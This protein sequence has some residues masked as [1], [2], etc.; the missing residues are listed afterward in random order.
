MSRIHRLLILLFGCAVAA[1]AQ[2][3][4]ATGTIQGTVL[5]A[6]GGAVAGARISA[7]HTG[8]GFTRATESNESGQFRLAA[9][10]AGDYDLRIEK[11]GFA[12]VLIPALPLAVGQSLIQRI[13]LKP[14]P[15]SE[16]LE[17]KERPEALETAATTAGVALGFERIE[18]APA[19]NRNYLN[20]VLVAPAVAPSSGSNAQRSFAGLRSAVSDSGFSFAGLRGRNNSLSIDG[21]DNRDETTGGNRVAI[22]LEMVREFRVSTA[23]VGA[24][25]GGAGGVLN[26]VTRSGTNIWHG[27]ATFF[28]QH[29]V[30]NARNPEAETSRRPRFRRRQ[31]GV[32]LM[33]PLRRDRTFFAWALE[34]EQESSEEWSS[35]PEELSAS[36]LAHGLYRGLFPAG[37][38]ETG[39]SFKADHQAGTQHSL[40][41]RY[42]FSRGRIRGDV[43]DTDNFA[44][45]SARGSSLTVDHSLVGGWIWVPTPHLVSDLRVQLARRSVEL[46]PNARGPLMEIPGLLSFG[47]SY[48]LD[49]DRAEDHFELREALH[50][51]A[52]PNQLSLGANLH[53]V[54]LDARLANRFAG[55]FIF[56]TLE[57]WRLARPDVYLRAFG[58]PRTHYGTLPLGA[59][60]QER[61]QLGAGLTLE[62]GL[63]YDR[64]WLPGDFPESGGN[65]APRLGVAW[66]PRGRGPYVV[67]AGLGWFYDRYPLAFLNE[68]LQ[69]NGQAAFEQ[70]LVGEDAVRAFARTLAGSAAGPFPGAVH[71]VYRPAPRFPTTYAGKLVFG[72]ERSLGPDT[73]VM[74]EYSL[75]R[76]RRLPRIRNVSGGLPPMYQLE[77]TA[78]SS[79]RGTSLAVQR[80][81]SRELA[82][83]IAYNQG[84]TLDDASDYDEQPQNPSDAAADWAH[85]RQHQPH[86]L[87]ASALFELPAEEL[88][89][90]PAG[91][92]RALANVIVAPIVTAGRGRPI[93]A[94]QTTDAFR[95]GAYPISARPW[96]LA[97]NPFF[98]PS[99][100]SMDMRIMKGFWLKQRRAILQ[101]GL[102]AF[103][104]TNH[105][106]PLRVSP[107][108]ATPNRRLD[109]YNR[110]VETLNARQ[111]QFMIQIEY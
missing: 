102:E 68:A 35:A 58:D 88:S 4:L 7:T 32:S 28:A 69:K 94:L 96:G 44:E 1:S 49:G 79:Y 11:E 53:A 70:Y 105:G 34:H 13:E 65:L 23:V 91:L 108:F 36:P 92:R 39:F 20:F 77:Q 29:E 16:R 75:V 84:R 60:I 26:V 78:R 55:V 22:G 97:R 57:D 43:Q 98:S 74:L 17:V 21:V 93:N 89:R 54:R 64:Q 38:A 42:A 2:A 50:L 106:N 90:L 8:M 63:R 31:P 110:A 109:S 103:N 101:T 107:Y 14:A 76:G 95:T 59:W 67:R 25:L 12:G 85:S 41:A 48:R 37:A 56:P 72:L 6:S 40:S 62:A 30:L 51:A 86:R 46:R 83:L 5:D 82:F 3:S 45:R 104:L 19:A 47:Q 52:G 24:E 71:S 111:I 9:L 80:R 81:L 10:P 87:A 61:R 100:F 27:D 18:E 33:G 15:V 73:T 66:R 99:T